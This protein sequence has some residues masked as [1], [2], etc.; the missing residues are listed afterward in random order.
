MLNLRFIT[1]K[2]CGVPADLWSQVQLSIGKRAS[3]TNPKAD[4]RPSLGIR[5]TINHNSLEAATYET[6]SRK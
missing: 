6:L 3:A 5:T 4:T 2:V 1:S